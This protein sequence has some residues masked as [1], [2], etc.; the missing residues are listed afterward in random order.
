MIIHHVGGLP[1][2]SFGFLKI[3]S[4][5]YLWAKNFCFSEKAAQH[6]TY[7]LKVLINDASATTTLKRENGS[8]C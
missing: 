5:L 2:P 1:V 3:A 6:E 4:V 7:S 8:K